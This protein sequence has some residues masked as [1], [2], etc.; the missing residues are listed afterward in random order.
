M[1]N[2]TKKFQ[3]PYTNGYKDRPDTSTPVT[4]KIKNAETEALLAIEEYLAKN[5]ITSFSIDGLLNKGYSIAI[6]EIDGETYNLNIPEL[7]YTSAISGGTKI[8]QISLGEKSYDLYAPAGGSG[9]GS[10]VAVDTELSATSENPVQ[11][12]V[13]NAALENKMDKSLETLI[14]YERGKTGTLAFTTTEEMT[15]LIASYASIMN[16]NFALAFNSILMCTQFKNYLSVSSIDC[17]L[18]TDYKAIYFVNGSAETNNLPTGFGGGILLNSTAGSTSAA[19]YQYVVDFTNG[20]QYSRSYRSGTW[21]A[22]SETTSSG[23]NVT[24]D[25]ELSDTSEN[26]VKN[27]VITAKLNEVFQSVSEGKSKIA[28]AIT[29]KGITT[30]ADAT[31]QVMAD[32]IGKISVSSGEVSGN[33]FRTGISMNVILNFQEV[34]WNVIT[35]PNPSVSASF[36]ESIVTNWNGGSYIGINIYTAYPIDL[37]NIKSIKIKYTESAHY[38][39]T[40][41][42]WLGI[43]STKYMTV[44]DPRNIAFD[45]KVSNTTTG[46][47][48]ITMDVS[49]ISG[50]KYIYIMPIGY[51]CTITDLILENEVDTRFEIAE[52]T[53][54]L[55]GSYYSTLIYTQ[56]GAN[57]YAVKANDNT[58][59]YWAI[60]FITRWSKWHV[61][62]IVSNTADYAHAIS[63]IMG[64]LSGIYSFEYENKTYYCNSTLQGAYEW[65]SPITYKAIP[66]YDVADPNFSGINTEAAWTYMAKKLLDFYFG[67]EE[68]PQ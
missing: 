26:P 57:Y 12:K 28:A 6:V 23:G 56:A 9:S 36:G 21:T 39:D 65:T 16:N 40:F 34:T 37:T 52:P 50:K 64:S 7:A 30:A 11:N 19:N 53:E 42:F 33:N 5:N 32:N 54:K 31:F 61:P 18:L 48:E 27:K 14:K 29:D 47:S 43:T 17:D 44:V 25:S 66:L 67:K 4:A 63:A 20:K 55:I 58:S 3:K 1:A 62:V 38:G 51:T 59:K 68:F 22:W 60:G 2:Y 35:D 13:V 8:G 45:K 46:E 15:E 41:P 49:D 10:T 24:I